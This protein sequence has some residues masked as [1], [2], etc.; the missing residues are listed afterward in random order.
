MQLADLLKP[1]I[2]DRIKI[3]RTPWL[4]RDV[5]DFED[6]YID[7]GITKEKTTC[8]EEDKEAVTD[9][10][11]LFAENQESSGEGKKRRRSRKKIL[12]KG[13]PGIGKSTLVAK[14]AYEWA[15]SAWKMFS[16]VFF[17]SMR[18][19]N[20][21]DPIENIII[22]EN[23]VPSVYAK[24]YDRSKILQLIQD[25]GERCLLIFDDLDGQITNEMVLR[26]IKDLA[27]TNCHI[28]LTARPNAAEGIE[29]YFTTICNVDGFSEMHATKYV[30]KLLRNKDKIESVMNFTKENQSIGVYEMWRYPTLLLFICILVNNGNLDLQSK[31]ITLT[32]I[33]DRLLLC[34]YRRYVVKRGIMNDPKKREEILLKLGQLAYEG[35]QKGKLLYSKR[36][37]EEKVG[38]EAFYY[39]IIIGYKDRCIVQDIDADFLVCFLHQTIQD[40]LAAIYIT[41]ELSHSQ[42]R[43]QDLW[44]QVWDTD[45]LAKFPLLFIFVADLCMNNETAHGKLFKSTLEIFN[46]HSLEVQGNLMG[47]KILNFLFKI[48]DKCHHLKVI[49]F[50]NTR[51][52]DNSS[53]ISN[54]VEHKPFSIEK[55]VFKRCVFYTSEND[56]CHRKPN[57]KDNTTFA[58][59]CLECNIP[60]TSITFLAKYGSLDTLVLNTDHITFSQSNKKHFYI[61]FLRLLDKRCM[62]SLQHL[63]IL[64]T[65]SVML[66]QPAT[67]ADD[68]LK[69]S[70]NNADFPACK[71]NLGGLVSLDIDCEFNIPKALMK[72]IIVAL[73]EK[74]SLKSIN[75]FSGAGHS[76]S[77]IVELSFFD[78]LVNQVSPVLQ[79]LTWKNV[80]TPDG[81]ACLERSLF[82]DGSTSRF[83]NEFGICHI[84]NNPISIPRGILPSIQRIDFS[85]KFI[86]CPCHKSG[87]LHAL[88]S[89][90][91]LKELKLTH[92]WL[93]YFMQLLKMGG[94]PALEILEIKN[95]NFE[96]ERIIEIGKE[97]QAG[98]CALPKLGHL[99][100]SFEYGTTPS[101]I[102]IHQNL[103][104]QFLI[105]VR[106][107][108]YLTSVNISG[109]NAGG[110]LYCLLV[111]E[112][113]PMLE[114]LIAHNCGLLPID[115]FRLG[116]AA[117]ANS[118]PN[119]KSLSLS[120]NPKIANHLCYLCIGSWA[121]LV[122]IKVSHL[123]SWD[124]VC[125]VHSGKTI[126]PN[127]E[128]I[129]CSIPDQ[130]LFPVH[131]SVLGKKWIEVRAFDGQAGKRK[132]SS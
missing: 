35:L 107:S 41:H 120:G 7:L 10:K 97:D 56:D 46:K 78:Q 53:T 51:W 130:K 5:M 43:M 100:L 38:K 84:H 114:E 24:N 89:H 86:C 88:D 131:K 117:K 116:K 23:I 101:N 73:G 17:I 99:D 29:H 58:V 20:P 95:H 65:G 87:I 40:Y 69:F 32:D 82:E 54:F 1:D 33:Y 25:Y 109:Q 55:L 63:K 125:L 16:L 96:L 49:T 64:S 26:I 31:N 9:Y 34:L 8:F 85:Q 91:I 106:G 21:G 122:C 72:M 22:D 108:F 59:H 92:L 36:E 68:A 28:V 39:G 121:S 18:V 127:L 110:C 12:I 4:E 37:I 123:S 30:R 61:S 19:V 3:Q 70:L 71:G 102:L 6:T 94:L 27:L 118:L 57:L 81:L 124:V 75:I 2:E 52:D 62:K 90:K 83:N 45:T 13:D 98:V 105:S 48:L 79:E 128:A 15:T 119:V 112:G 115:I 67:T 113:L 80:V 66:T 129:L 126:M 11:E 44:P 103:L 42:R 132:H 111:P 77:G 76:T 50:L 104:K 74:T 14:M 47:P 60:V 93:P